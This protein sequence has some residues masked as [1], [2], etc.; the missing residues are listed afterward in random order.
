MADETKELQGIDWRRCF[1]FLE[2]LRSFRMAVHPA[3]LVLCLAGLVASVGLAVLVDQVPGIGQ[4]DVNG[5]SCYGNLHAIV[6]QTLWGQW[7][8][9]YVGGSTLDDFGT[10]LMAPVSAVRDFVALGVTYWQ[11]DTWFAL[12]MTVLGLAIW[13][14]VGGAV[15]RMAAVRVAREENVPLKKAVAFSLG[16]W[17][18][19]VTSPL[20]PFGV[21]VLMAIVVG[22]LTGLPLMIPYAGEFVI[23]V[24]FGLTLLAGLIMA[25]VL[26]GGAVSVGLQWPTIAAEG[27]DSFDA[28]SRSV[29]YITSRPWR[30]LFYAAFST[31]YGC[32]TFIFIKLLAFLSLRITHAAVSTFSM[33]RGGAPDKLVRLWD[34][35]TLANP[36]PA[37]GAPDMFWGEAAA[38]YLFQFWVWVVL[39]VVLA[40]LVS[41]FFTSQTVVY[42]LMRKTVDATDIEEVYM[43]E[44]DEEELP[45]EH[46]I[47]GPEKVES[48]ASAEEGKSADES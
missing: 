24:L 30:Y 2:I 15:T 21:L 29:S 12:V 31:L 39:G 27:S 17:P 48:E 33:G 19:L 9:P 16:K 43:E 28:I 10:F 1:A 35:P 3:K 38:T 45:V 47:E 22:L 37:A 40:F 25:L 41:F 6:T 13:A 14:L 8:F 23:G 42:F 20:I 7:A 4:T 32:L 26:V 18:S 44:G 46:K 11:Q 36:W 5:R 34:V